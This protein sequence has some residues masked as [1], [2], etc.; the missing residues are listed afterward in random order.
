MGE[1]GVQVE[2]CRHDDPAQNLF[3]IPEINLLPYSSARQLTLLPCAGDVP[4]LRMTGE[5][6]PD[7]SGKEEIESILVKVLPTSHHST[8]PD[9][10]LRANL[11]AEA[12]VTMF[13]CLEAQSILA[14]GF[15]AQKLMRCLAAK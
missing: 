4:V 11:A 3:R 14:S 10:R 6:E 12:H 13:G 15:I 7:D 1:E 9:K 5:D 2:A 8:V